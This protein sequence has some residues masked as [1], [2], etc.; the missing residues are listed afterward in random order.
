MSLWET[1][2]L[3]A[4]HEKQTGNDA[5]FA[6]LDSST[7]G[8][9]ASPKFAHVIGKGG[10]EEENLP[11]KNTLKWYPRMASWQFVAIKN[12]PLLDTNRKLVYYH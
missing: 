8:D 5:H 1:K 4:V 11:G 7:R 9:Q 12:I 10:R 3:E 2:I 6:Y